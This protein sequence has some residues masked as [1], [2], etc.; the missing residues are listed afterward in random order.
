MAEKMKKV[1]K[2]HPPYHGTWKLL[3]TTGMLPRT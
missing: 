3:K 2:K 1:P